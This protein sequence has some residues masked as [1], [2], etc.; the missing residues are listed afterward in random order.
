MKSIIPQISI[1][2][3]NWN[4]KKWIKDCFDS[5]LLQTFK[6]FEIIFVD[7]ASTDDSIEFVKANYPNV[8]IVSNSSNL[9]FAGGNNA[10]YKVAK[11]EYI[12]L[13][14][15]DT[16]LEPNVL[17]LT[18]EAFDKLP[19]VAAVQPKL[20]L[21]KEPDLMDSCG[22][23][24]TDTTILYHYGL[25]K[26]V[27]LEKYNVPLYVFSN[28]G[29]AI[30]LRKNIIDEIGLFDDEQWCYYEESD[31]CH[32]IWIYGYECLYYPKS[33]VLHAV[34][35]TSTQFDNSFVQFH[36]F[37]NKLH[38]Y[39][40]NFELLTLLKVVPMH[41]LVVMVSCMIW[42][43]SGKISLAFAVL[44]SIVWNI[45]NARGILK[46]RKQI[47]SI[48]K[49]SDSEVFVKTKRNPKLAYYRLM[50]SGYEG[51]KKYEDE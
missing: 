5:I 10:G 24:W 3:V 36:S 51:L 47:Q 4:G 33:T 28:K 46:R 21:M 1:I 8:I 19:K 26:N 6:D 42:I 35:G 34:G 45:K 12:F 43:A 16:K 48:R 30:M 31:L 22:S 40:S 39:L 25:A 14:N 23:F 13:L 9:G 11:G 7:N 2:I 41:L 37:K 50:M 32:R 29:A 18:L 38:S 27:H 17:E 15:T 49:C 20:V 44:K